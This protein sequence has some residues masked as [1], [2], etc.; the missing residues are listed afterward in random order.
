MCKRVKPSNDA[1]K[2]IFF[3]QTIRYW[4]DPLDSL[5]SSAE[6]SDDCVSKFTSL[7][8]AWD[9]IFLAQALI[10]Y[11]HFGV[12]PVNYSDS[13]SEEQDTGLDTE[14]PC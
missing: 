1:Y 9:L 3:P 14:L 12:S 2:K 13:D 4:N 11:C 8:R 6:Q 5:I 10:R 7:V